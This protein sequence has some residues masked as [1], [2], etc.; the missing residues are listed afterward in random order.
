MAYEKRTKFPDFNYNQTN[1][2]QNSALCTKL[3]DFYTLYIYRKQNLQ[4]GKE[5]YKTKDKKSSEN[6]GLNNHQAGR[7]FHSSSKCT[8][9]NTPKIPLVEGL[10]LYKIPYIFPIKYTYKNKMHGKGFL[11]DQ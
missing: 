4:N 6:E 11:H 10:N 2:L 1:K 3:T 8:R 9:D 5:Q 7:P